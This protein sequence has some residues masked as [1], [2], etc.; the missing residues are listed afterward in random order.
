MTT[1]CDQHSRMVHKSELHWLVGLALAVIGGIALAVWSFTIDTY[2][3]RDQVA[4]CEKRIDRTE[5]LYERIDTKL[6][7]LLMRQKR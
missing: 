4:N 7:Q 3:T 5:R 6:D 2:A 1:V